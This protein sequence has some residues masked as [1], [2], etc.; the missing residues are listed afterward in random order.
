MSAELQVVSD[1]P[2]KMKGGHD[3]VAM[4]KKAVAQR[5]ANVLA[6]LTRT[7][8]WLNA[9]AQNA[10]E[11]V[12][13]IVEGEEPAHPIRLAAAKDILDRTVGKA[14]QEIR[15]GPA[16]QTLDILRELDG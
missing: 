1:E 5:E 13:D 10:A 8:Q 2:R 7:R 12:A 14:A 6:D 11:Y 4:G 16:E 3:P 15:V 9:K